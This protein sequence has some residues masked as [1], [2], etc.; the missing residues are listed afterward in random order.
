MKHRYQ[1]PINSER[2][3]FRP[4]GD[5]DLNQWE[6]FFID[7]PDLAFVGISTPESPSIESKKWIER[8]VKR[9]SE[10][11]VGILGA[12]LKGSDQLIGNCGLIWREGIIG[13]NL[14]EIGYSIIPAYWQKGFA[15][16][17]AIRFR[18]Y[19]EKHQLGNK[20]IS[21]I[22]LNNIGSQKV[23]VNN[24]MQ[25]GAQFNFQGS[26]CYQYFRTY[27]NH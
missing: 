11:G 12:Y 13:E 7:N 16:E 24:G 19:F 2:L 10:S 9:Y 17:M 20:V 1:F 8:Q 23:A 22:A 25:R 3:H 26:A 14:Y 6:A 15:T 21:I 27:T 18:K 5:K 4:L